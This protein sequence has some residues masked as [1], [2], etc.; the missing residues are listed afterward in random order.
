VVDNLPLA[1]P[2]PKP[3]HEIDIATSARIRQFVASREVVSVRHRLGWTSAIGA[4]A[5]CRDG[6]LISACGERTPLFLQHDR[7]QFTERAPW[8]IAPY[9]P[10]WLQGDFV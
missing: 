3:I 4:T 6:A 1:R 5:R 7:Q 9:G 8:Y 2:G 10:I